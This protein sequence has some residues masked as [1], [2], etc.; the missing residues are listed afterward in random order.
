MFGYE[1]HVGYSIKKI[2]S[3]KSVGL[4]DFQMTL[5]VFEDSKYCILTDLCRKKFYVV[6]HESISSKTLLC[7]Y[8]HAVIFSVVLNVS[9]DEFVSIC[10]L[11]NFIYSKLINVM[12]T[13]AG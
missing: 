4:K 2:V 8:F 12:H 3:D 6:L 5:D 9:N 10:M 13:Y 11:I 1:I 7:A